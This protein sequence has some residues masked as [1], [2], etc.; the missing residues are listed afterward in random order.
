MSGI[1]ISSLRSNRTSVSLISANRDGQLA[2][3]QMTRMIRKGEG[4]SFLVKDTDNYKCIKF[5]YHGNFITYRWDKINKKLE[6][7]IVSQLSPEC[8]APSSAFNGIIGENLKVEYMDFRIECKNGAQCPIIND[9]Y[10][11]NIR[12]P[13]ITIILR[14]GAKKTPIISS[15]AFINLQTTV[16]PRVTGRY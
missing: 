6:S 11:S 1:F 16:S 7:N 13:K 2:L 4:E 15:Q 5:T 10:D 14:I 9:W 3:E 8:D 12:F